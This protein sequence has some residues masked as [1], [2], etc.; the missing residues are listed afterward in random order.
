MIRFDVTNGS[1]IEKTYPTNPHP[2]PDL[3]LEGGGIQ[4]ILSP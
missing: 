1:I 4:A 2:P 3:P